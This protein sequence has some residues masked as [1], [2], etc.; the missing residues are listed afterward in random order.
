VYTREKYEAGVGPIELTVRDKQSV[1]TPVWAGVAA[2][3]AGVL[4]LVVRPKG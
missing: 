3:V 4:Q 1:I 2:I